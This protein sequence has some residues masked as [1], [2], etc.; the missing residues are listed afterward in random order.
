MPTMAD[1]EQITDG[2]ARSADRTAAV[3]RFI[4]RFGAELEAAGVPRMPARIFAALLASDDG[5]LTAAELS[6]LL[7]VTAPSVSVAVRYLTQLRLVVRE[8]VPGTRRESYRVYSDLWYEMFARRDR[9]LQ[10]WQEELAAGI[11]AVGVASRAGVR[12][13]EARQFCEFIRTEVADLMDR[14]RVIRAATAE[15]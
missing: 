15:F 9:A 3:A 13:E 1:G 10:R 6:E 2:D 14:W 12:L 8:R 5:S 4:E 11:V 7:H